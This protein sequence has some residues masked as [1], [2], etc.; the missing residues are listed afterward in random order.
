MLILM[1]SML[2]NKYG[3]YSPN[4]SPRKGAKTLSFYNQCYKFIYGNHLMAL[5]HCI[6]DSHPQRNN[7]LLFFKSIP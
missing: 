2:Y 5:I 3:N 7:T 4:M 1:L 6:A